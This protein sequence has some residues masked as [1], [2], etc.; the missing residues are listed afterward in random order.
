MGFAAIQ[1]TRFDDWTRVGPAPVVDHPRF[2][3][4][5]AS[6]RRD[7]ETF[8]W[9]CLDL[10]RTD[11]G[12]ADLEFEAGAFGPTSA[13]ESQLAELIGSLDALTRAAVRAVAREL[14]DCVEIPLPTDPWRNLEWQ[15]ARLSGRVGTFQLHYW[16]SPAG[17]AL[18]TVRFEQSKPSGVRFHD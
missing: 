13:H 2:G 11:R 5:R 6:L 12:L 7:S 15:G 14:S 8:V 16:C 18:I 17:D 10:V 3:A 1:V 4:I 9:E